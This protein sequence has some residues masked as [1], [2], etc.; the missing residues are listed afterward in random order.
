MRGWEKIGFKNF[1]FQAED[2]IRDWS[3]TGVQT[4]ALPICVYTCMC[5]FVC[6]CVCNSHIRML[7]QVT[8]K[9]ERKWYSCKSLDSHLA[10]KDSFRVYKRALRSARTFYYSS[11]IEDNRNNPRFLFSTVARLTKSHN[12]VV[13]CISATLS[14][15]DFMSF[16]SW[17]II[18]IRAEINQAQLPTAVDVSSVSVTPFGPGLTLDCF[19]LVD[20]PELT[21]TISKAKPSTCLLDS[22]PTRLLKDVM[23]L[24]GTSILDQINLSLNSGYVPQVFKVAV[25]KPLLK[26][27]SLD[28]DILANYRPISNLPFIS[29]ILERVVASQL[30][31][32]LHRNDLFEVFQSGF[33]IHHSTETELVRV[34]NNLLM[35]SDHGLVSILVLL[36]LRPWISVHTGSAGPQTMD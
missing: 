34:T 29:K 27:P 20:L 8:Q 36:D 15:E 18:R 33:R 6:V 11:L 10:W 32:H 12:S 3:V 13:P 28:P 9:M 30:G 31:D 7:K 21:S 19:S 1:F 35:A 24:I 22:I 14:S 17:K 23:S 4:C 26:K 5:V 25:M 16:F 2:G